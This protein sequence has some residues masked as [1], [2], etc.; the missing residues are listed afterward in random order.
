MQAYKRSANPD[1]LGFLLDCAKETLFVQRDVIE[2]RPKPANKPQADFKRL[3]IIEH[4]AVFGE[5]FLQLFE[6][7]CWNHAF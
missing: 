1:S 4:N 5:Q 2:H 3:R 7:I 6:P